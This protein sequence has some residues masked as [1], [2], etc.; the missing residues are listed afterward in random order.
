MVGKFIFQQLIKMDQKIIK[1]AKLAYDVSGDEKYLKKIEKHQ[2]HIKD[3]Q[4]NIAR[5][6]KY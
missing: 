5:F 3:C 6:D 2:R 1:K 4:K